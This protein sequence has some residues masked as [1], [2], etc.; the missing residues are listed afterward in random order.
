M[1]REELKRMLSQVDEQYIAEIIDAEEMTYEAAPAPRRA[2]RFAGWAA[3]AAAVCICTVGGGLLLGGV[4]DMPET[5]S[6]ASQSPSVSVGTSTDTR[7]EEHEAYDLIWE[8][9]ENDA[10][11]DYTW[12]A[13]GESVKVTN[14]ALPFAADAYSIREAHFNLDANGTPENMY[15]IVHGGGG[16]NTIQITLHEKGYLFPANFHVDLSADAGREKPAIHIYETTNFYGED[17][18]KQSFELYFIWNGVGFSMECDGIPLQEAEQ[19]AASFLNQTCAGL[20]AENDPSRYFALESPII[21]SADFTMESTGGTALVGEESPFFIVTPFGPTYFEG[22][23]YLREDGSAANILLSYS[24][25]DKTQNAEVIISN[26]GK[27]YAHGQLEAEGGVERDGV[28][29]FGST[30]E[31]GSTVL[32][33]NANRIE[34]VDNGE[35]KFS[36]NGWDCQITCRGMS[37]DEVICFYDDIAMTLK[38]IAGIEQPAHAYFFRDVSEITSHRLDQVWNGLHEV[39]IEEPELNIP[40]TLTSPRI[41]ATGDGMAQF[42][43]FEYG[44]ENGSANIYLNAHG[45]MGSDFPITGEADGRR[46]NGVMVYGFSDAADPDRKELYFLTKEGMG[47]SMVCHKLPEDR[48]LNI[49]RQIMDAGISLQLLLEKT[50]IPEK[51][52]YTVE[53]ETARKTPATPN[54]NAGGKY[55]IFGTGDI[56]FP[57]DSVSGYIYR[58]KNGTPVNILVRTTIGNKQVFYTLSD[59]EEFYLQYLDAD[60][61]GDEDSDKPV[62]HITEA[63]DSTGL[64]VH[65]L[66]FQYPGT[67][68]SMITYNCTAEETLA[69]AGILLRDKPTAA[70]ASETV[71]DREIHDRGDYLLVWDRGPVAYVQL[72]E[73][74]DA[75]E[76][77]Y[78]NSTRIKAPQLPFDMGTYTDFAGILYR[79]TE[80]K[81]FAVYLEYKM[82]KGS[83]KL[84]IYDAEHPSMSPSGSLSC[85]TLSEEY[86]KP[87]LL[88]LAVSDNHHRFCYT[89]DGTSVVVDATGYA[90]DETEQMVAAVFKEKLT[91]KGISFAA[92]TVTPTNNTEDPA[93]YFGCTESVAF[94]T[95]TYDKAFKRLQLTQPE[96]LFPS[97]ADEEKTDWICD[98][99]YDNGDPVLANIFMEDA[100]IVIGESEWYYPDG[101]ITEEPGKER[102]GVELYGHRGEW[103]LLAFI[104]D[105]W[106]CYICAS[107]EL[108][109]EEWVLTLADD[110]ILQGYT[111]ESLHTEF[112]EYLTAEY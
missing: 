17:T 60:T 75:S 61:S 109:S 87:V 48:V 49:A 29:L 34:I 8:T 100:F 74:D 41:Y 63:K 82:K 67:A 43:L 89:L 110:M 101:V 16:D 21:V 20:F 27:M 40:L 37:N 83:I 4:Q 102:H 13:G 7:I 23:Y 81:P 64:T 52:A 19:I 26:T 77:T 84:K 2:G 98:I 108:Y 99:S 68:V 85:M 91:A 25:Q 95:V 36:F 112:G 53:W 46:F 10:C 88:G 80:N 70:S 62:I 105:G 6:Q 90:A 18:A 22:S 28:T 111:P 76:R 92:E 55:D 79:D 72:A 56:A 57:A 9:P 97:I 15:L 39:P 50:A 104:K 94:D 86:G 59:A 96:L 66:Y 38:T 44:D 47:C 24:N 42:A 107:P 65:E 103:L 93:S 5:S 106:S 11:I 73:P 71:S 45:D 14:P 3:I 51:E 35:T 54:C 33:F 32:S 30:A 31:D 69:Y 12:D 1:K 78:D 58:D